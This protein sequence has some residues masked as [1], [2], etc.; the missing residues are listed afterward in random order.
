MDQDAAS[1]QSEA[2]KALISLFGG[3]KQALRHQLQ[4]DGVHVAAPMLLR[5]LQLCERHPGITQQGLAQL[6][7]R[8]KGQVAR[9]VK[10]L[11][12]DGLLTRDAHPDDK[13][14]HRLRP[15]IAGQAAVERFVVAE[16]GAAELIFGELSTAE[17]S[18]LTEQLRLLRARLDERLACTDL[19]PEKRR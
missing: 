12:D 14:S 6:T 1:R 13:R 15:T 5:M 9:L 17:L 2:L 10:Q 18:H 3:M 4:G 19:A 11:L 8:D 16:M 7:G